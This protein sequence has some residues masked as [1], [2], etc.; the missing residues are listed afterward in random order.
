MNL[1]SVVYKTRQAI[2]IHDVIC[3]LARELLQ[4]NRYANRY[5]S[6]FEQLEQ[7][8]DRQVE[9]FHHFYSLFSYFVLS[10]AT[11]INRHS[12]TVR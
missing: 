12:K 8:Y 2:E 9:T 6:K 3:W 10:A 11:E 7:G 1:S 4:K 5:I